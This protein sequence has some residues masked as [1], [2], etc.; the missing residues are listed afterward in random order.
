GAGAPAA[1]TL[2]PTGERRSGIFRALSRVPEN[3]GVL[4]IGVDNSTGIPSSLS[5]RSQSGF[6]TAA[7]DLELEVTDLP[8]SVPGFFVVSPDFNI[9]PMAGGSTGTLCIASQTIGR[10]LQSFSV[11]ATSGDVG[12]LLDNTQIPLPGGAIAVAPGDRLNFQFWHR[13]A[14]ALGAPTSNFSSAIAITFQ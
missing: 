13:D 7:N 6:D 11:S 12:Y 1:I 9:S 2:S 5:A 4:C 14:G 3:G 10:I 8:P